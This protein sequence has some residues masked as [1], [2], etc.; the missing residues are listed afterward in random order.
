MHT[1]AGM[2]S[3]SL[4][5]VYRPAGSAGSDRGLVRPRRNELLEKNKDVE[6]IT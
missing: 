6:E 3:A 4:R 2:T 5:P 1:I